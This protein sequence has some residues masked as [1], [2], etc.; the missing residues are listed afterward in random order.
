MSVGMIWQAAATA[1]YLR[2]VPPDALFYYVHS[3]AIIA[4]E[5]EAV[6][7]ECDYGIRFAAVIEFRNVFATQ[8]HPEKSQRHGLTVLRNFIEAN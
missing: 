1:S 6:V 4:N 8:F 5:P 7:A 2:D 3:F